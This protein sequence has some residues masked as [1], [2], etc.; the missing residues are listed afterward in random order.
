[1][2]LIKVEEVKNY[3]DSIELGTPSKGGALKI[4]FDA[5]NPEETKTRIDNANIAL[6]Y[7]R[8]TYKQETKEEK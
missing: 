5:S 8:Q 1:M 6:E 2:T 3:P 4:Y 7:A